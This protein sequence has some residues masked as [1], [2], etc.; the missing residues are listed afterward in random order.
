MTALEVKVDPSEVTIY[1][2][3]KD[4]LTILPS[5]FIEKKYSVVPPDTKFDE[6]NMLEKYQQGGIYKAEL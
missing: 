6:Q 2:A 3:G 4:D 5:F 1:I